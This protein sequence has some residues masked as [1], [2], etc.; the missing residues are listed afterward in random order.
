[1]GILALLETL[2][3]CGH[4]ELEPLSGSMA[5]GI[6]AEVGPQAITDGWRAQ[7]PGN[8]AL[9]LSRGTVS[10]PMM[11]AMMKAGQATHTRR[12]SRTA[13]WIVKLCQAIFARVNRV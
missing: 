5:I 7:A 2:Q 3:K 6:V 4:R 1:M 8:H 10:S 13:G 9:L 11:A 12:A